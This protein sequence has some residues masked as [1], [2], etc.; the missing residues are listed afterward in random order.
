MG[1]VSAILLAAYWVIRLIQWLIIIYVIL[2]WI[3]QA[4]E[5]KWGKILSMLIEPILSPV[6][7]LLSKID[8]L[9]SLPIDLSPIAAW[10]FLGILQS[11][12][13]MMM[14]IFWKI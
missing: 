9:K 8:A 2:S 3:P 10:L 6:R 4:R 11:I 5:S 13:Q 7:L 1:I 12:I 14:S